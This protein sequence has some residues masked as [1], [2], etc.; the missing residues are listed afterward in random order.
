M[1]V[2]SSMAFGRQRCNSWAEAH[3]STK[4]NLLCTRFYSCCL[5]PLQLF[6]SSW[7]LTSF[8]LRT[9]LQQSSRQ[10][11]GLGNL[12]QVPFG[13]SFH[14]LVRWC[15]WAET[16]SNTVRLQVSCDVVF[17]QRWVPAKSIISSSSVEVSNTCAGIVFCKA[18]SL[19]D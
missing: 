9:S 16:S 10:V 17:T 18:S 11:S 3:L 13:G 4:S 8:K 6:T 1:L 15:V 7:L 5:S 14:N 19:G 12:V 2:Q